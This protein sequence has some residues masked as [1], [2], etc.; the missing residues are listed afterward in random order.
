MYKSDIMNLVT[1]A[2]REFSYNENYKLKICSVLCIIKDKAFEEKSSIGNIRIVVR[3]CNS[4]IYDVET[5]DYGDIFWERWEFD[6][7]EM[8]LKKDYNG[9]FL[10]E[11]FKFACNYVVRAF[12]P[13]LL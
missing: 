4:V 12:A 10:V 6:I 1:H 7:D 8:E 9:K 11:I 5:K 3:D 13:R 2:N